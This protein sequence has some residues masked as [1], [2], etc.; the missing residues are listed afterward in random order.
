MQSMLNEDG[1]VRVVFATMALGM[2]VNFVGLTTTIHYGAP[3]NI[4]DY[5]TIQMQGIRCMRFTRICLQC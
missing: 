1:I 3:R 5:S 4:D 2:G